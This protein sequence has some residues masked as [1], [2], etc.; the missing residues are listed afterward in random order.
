MADDITETIARR[1]FAT[2][3]RTQCPKWDAQPESVKAHYRALATQF[4]REPGKLTRVL[5]SA[6]T[7]TRQ[8]TS[9]IDRATK[10]WLDG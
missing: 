8:A 3:P 2:E 6:A 5:R 9:D 1:W 4:W 7:S 10:A